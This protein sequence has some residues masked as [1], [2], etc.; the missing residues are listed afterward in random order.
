[1]SI[2][3]TK[4][5]SKEWN[6]KID[7]VMELQDST[8]CQER[9]IKETGVRVQEINQ[10]I[11]EKTRN[12]ELHKKIYLS[13]NS[14]IADDI[15][16]LNTQIANIVSRQNQIRQSN[17][18]IQQTIN[19][20][21]DEKRR[22]A[23]SGTD[24]YREAKAQ[25]I[26]MKHD[27]D[28]NKFAQQE[29]V[30]LEAQFNH[31]ANTNW[32]DIAMLT[33]AQ[34][35]L[36]DVYSTAL[37]VNE[38][39]RNYEE[40]QKQCITVATTILEQ[41][42]EIRNNAKLDEYANL[43]QDIDFWTGNALKNTEDEVKQI[44]ETIKVNRNNP[45]FQLQELNDLL[46]KLDELKKKKDK[47]IRCAIE[48][49]GHSARAQ[50]EVYHAGEILMNRHG[51]NF[52]GADYE[53]KDERRPFIARYCRA[54]DGMEVEF[55]SVFDQASDN[56]KFIHRMNFA[57]YGDPN[58]LATLQ[59]GIINSLAASGGIRIVNQGTCAPETQLGAF[60]INN[61]Q[62]GAQTRAAHGISNNALT[63]V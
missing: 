40:I 53:M 32:T 54:Q 33:Q 38:S 4:V 18:E 21:L 31:G 25:F 61:P 59:Q 13:Q 16:L 55:I 62:I 20:L 58:I 10:L 1:M 22:L 14:A 34:M 23:Q 8:I 36:S 28:F 48:N 9:I 37:Q 15:S 19:R 26:L 42:N 35:L 41:A 47:I 44:L 5:D 7:K 2:G 50:A 49:V 51:F 56:Y 11:D 45:N 43:G 30:S 63:F 46:L 52:V 17:A 12:L 6:R 24:W 27:A 60:N 39:R 29:L 57:A 3:H